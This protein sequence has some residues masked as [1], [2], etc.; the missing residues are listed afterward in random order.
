M[1]VVVAAAEPATAVIAPSAADCSM[2]QFQPGTYPQLKRASLT[3]IPI[4]ENVDGLPA[5]PARG[6]RQA[7]PP[8]PPPPYTGPHHI[9]PT[10]EQP[11]RDPRLVLSQLSIWTNFAQ[12]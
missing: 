10:P 3:N 2:N 12:S 6:R 8:P 7:T 4:Y 1:A 9:V 11:A 5:V